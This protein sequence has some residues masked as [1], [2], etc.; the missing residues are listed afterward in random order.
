MSGDLDAERWRL[1]ELLQVRAFRLFMAGPDARRLENIDGGLR[2]AAW[3]YIP[4]HVRQRMAEMRRMCEEFRERRAMPPRY[5]ARY[6]R[7]A[8]EA[9]ARKK[10]ETDE[11]E[12]KA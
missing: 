8:R 6:E 11:G 12:D 10:A 9:D 5:R 1:V 2:P 3:R 4:E 7:L